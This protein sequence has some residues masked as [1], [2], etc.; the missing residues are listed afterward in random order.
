[1]GYL[2]HVQVYRDLEGL[3]QYSRSLS[4]FLQA[5]WGADLTE[6][7]VQRVFSAFGT[8]RKARRP[9]KS[10]YAALLTFCIRQAVPERALDIFNALQEVWPQSLANSG[11][12]III[13]FTG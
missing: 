6:V 11:Q 4:A 5:C 13:G 10:V 3:L 8:F 1:M 9:D 2:V 12:G 7:Q